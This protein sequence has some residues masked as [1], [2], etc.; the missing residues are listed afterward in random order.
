MHSYKMTSR[1][2]VY[3]SQSISDE[4]NQRLPK[5]LE[6]SVSLWASVSEQPKRIVVS[7]PDPTAEGSENETSHNIL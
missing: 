5:C 2:I 1:I 7:F 3:Y 6:R 4:G